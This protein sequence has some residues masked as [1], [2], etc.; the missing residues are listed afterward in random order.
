MRGTVLRTSTMNK[1][2]KAQKRTG[3]VGRNKK[4]QSEMKEGG[5]KAEM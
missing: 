3:N 1:V 4:R 2:N 5:K